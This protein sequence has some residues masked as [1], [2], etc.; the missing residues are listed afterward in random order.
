MLGL[1]FLKPDFA[2]LSDAAI[3]STIAT[4]FYLSGTAILIFAALA[5]KPSLRVSPIPRTGAPLIT[6]G[7]YK[8]F[9]HP[10]YL[11]VLL[12]GAGMTLTNLNFATIVI[13]LALFG[14]LITKGNFEDSLLR[15]RH[16]DAKTYQSRTRGLLGRKNA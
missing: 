14:T 7:I 6:F 3:F 10:M 11:A 12:F 15:D 4:I 16:P 9:R 8:Y 1:L 2:L 5:L 13:W